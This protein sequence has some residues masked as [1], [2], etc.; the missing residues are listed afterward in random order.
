MRAR[1]R[2]LGGE[3]GR[4]GTEAYSHCGGAHSAPGKVA[5]IGAG[6]GVPWITDKPWGGGCLGASSRMCAGRPRGTSATFWTRCIP[7]A[8]QPYST[9]TWPLSLMPSLLGVCWGKPPMVL[10]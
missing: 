2:V 6:D 1:V 9:F 10:R 8:S 7:S 4:R 5:G 3:R